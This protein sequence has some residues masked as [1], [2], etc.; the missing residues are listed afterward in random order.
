MSTNRHELHAGKG[1]GEASRCCLLWGSLWRGRL[2]VDQLCRRNEVEIPGQGRCF[3]RHLGTGGSLHDCPAHPLERLFHRKSGGFHQPDQFFGVDAVFSVAIGRS[4]PR[5]RGVGD[6]GTAGGIHAG[7]A[8]GCGAERSG[9][10]VV[11]ACIQN[12]DVHVAPRLLHLGQHQPGVHRLVTHLVLILDL[13]IHRNQVVGAT[14]LNSVAG[15]V[16][17]PHSARLELLAEALDRLV[18]LDKAEI[19]LFFHLKPE[20]PKSGRHGPGIIHRVLER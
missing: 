18:H 8:P 15:I 6:E 20:P 19:G 13:G 2:F 4:P 16:E 7:Q 17:Q 10:G 3:P 9:K 5:R 12:D 1:I 14:H 11:A